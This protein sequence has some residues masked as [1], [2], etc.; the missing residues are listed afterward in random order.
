M[1]GVN[2]YSRRGHFGGSLVQNIF[3]IYSPDG[4]NVYVSRDREFEGNG[5]IVSVWG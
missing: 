1:H 2:D 5:D 3:L 4:I